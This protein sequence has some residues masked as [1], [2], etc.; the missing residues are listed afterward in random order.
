MASKQPTQVK[1]EGRLN[2]RI[3]LI[4]EAPG[5]DEAL[6]G[7]PFCGA[8]YEKRLKWWWREAGIQRRDFYIDNVYP[9]KPPNNKLAAADPADVGQWT[10][11][12]HAR[13]AHLKNP[14]LIVVTGETAL[15]ALTGKR[16]IT[17][18]RGSVLPYE[19]PIDGRII[20]VVPTFHPAYTFRQPKHQWTCQ[21][22][23]KRISRELDAG[24][25]ILEPEVDHTALPTLEDIDWWVKAYV[26]AGPQRVAPVLVI[27]AEWAPIRK[28][29]PEIQL[30]CVGFAVDSS[31]SICI[32]TTYNY[33]GRKADLE[34]A[35]QW[36]SLLCE[37][38][39]PKV[40]HHGHSDAYVLG[41]PPYEIGIEAFDWDTLGMHHCLNP[42]SV[43]H[44]LDFLSSIYNEHYCFWK[45]EA[46]DPESIAK[47]ASD[48]HALYQYNG[49][50]VR[51]T[52]ELFQTFK[53][54]LEHRGLMD[55][56]VEFYRSVMPSL[57]RLSMHG[58]RVD[59][60]LRRKKNARLEVDRIRLRKT[61]IRESGVDVF[62]PKKGISGTRFQKWLYGK[63]E[64]QLGLRKITKTRKRATGETD[65]TASADAVALRRLMQ[66]YPDE[67]R[68]QAVGKAVLEYR[69]KSKLLEFY[70]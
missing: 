37:S 55:Q 62:G 45:E 57:I 9:F 46:K 2:S 7:R 65:R 38:D 12:L 21:Q 19:S 56:Y 68:L 49:K 5:K 52:Y 64:G 61:V 69:R 70:S 44:T 17:K 60:H 28:D 24:P 58:M 40:L 29:R 6:Q 63:D 18:W 22:D 14:E 47:Y 27:D 54:M 35:M 23:W 59:D 53:R 51:N 32:P 33:W 43:S 15:N 3:V 26:G 50:D 13:I 1:A 48:L 36:V 20:K 39:I 4:G 66:Q 16:G 41:M 11:N 25:E 34:A 30:L 10:Q 42:G 8:S 67:A 31:H